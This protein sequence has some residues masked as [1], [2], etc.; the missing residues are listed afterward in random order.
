MH[1]L[2][3][4]FVQTRNIRPRRLIQ[5][6]PR[7]NHDIDV[8]LAESFARIGSLDLDS[9]LLGVLVPYATQELVVRFDEAGGT[10]FLGDILQ[11]LLDFCARGV[12]RGPVRVGGKGVL[13]GVSCE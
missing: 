1:Q 8:L 4:E 12:E 6:A 3:P 11:I 5:K 7:G 2:A 10:E 13:V 9:P